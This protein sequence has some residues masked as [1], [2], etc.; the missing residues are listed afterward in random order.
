M[1]ENVKTLKDYLQ[2]ARRRKYLIAASALLLLVASIAVALIL[3][4]VYQS[5]ATILIE[6]QQIPT[7]LV[8]STV[9]SYADERI[10]LIQQRVMT[11]DNL[12][13]IIDKFNLY[14]EQKEKLTPAELAEQFRM[15]AHLELVNADVISQGRHSK[16]TLAFKLLFDDKDPLLAQKVTNELVTLFLNENVRNRTE[17]AEETTVFLE[18]EAQ[19][20]KI[21][22]Q[23][24]ENELAEYKEKY[25]DSLPELLPVNLSAVSRIE[26]E[27]QQLDLREKMLDERKI[28][29]RSQMAVAGQN[30]LASTSDGSAPRSLAELKL[31]QARLLSKYS[32]THPDVMRVKRQVEILESG[33]NPEQSEADSKLQEAKQELAKLRQQYSDNHPDVKVA[34]RKVAELTG[35][36]SPSAAKKPANQTISDPTLLQIKSEIDVAEVEL[37]NI[38]IHR[39]ELQEKLK[40]LEVNISQTHQVERG[41]YELMR[42]LDNN[43][44]KYNEL[45]A[46]QLEA[47]LAQTLE[48]EQKAEKF[49]LIEPPLLP[50]KPIKPNRL[51]LLFIGFIASI[52]G[53]FGAGLLREMMDD[54]IRGHRSLAHIVGA[55][56]LVVVPYIKSQ[57][58]IDRTRRNIIN[59][60]I[61]AG[62]LLLGMI[63]SVH[64][65]YMPLDI[66]WYKTWNRLGLI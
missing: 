57:E 5:Q 53:G 42:D 19:K 3:P 30:S 40:A 66:L 16:A 27:I 54:S 31:E 11:T 1:E 28:S 39:A 38:R 46:K 15:N 56:P 21:D 8:K 12:T 50:N 60:S 25:R 34:Q 47:K 9:T 52:G 43:K 20:F 65:L 7:D 14:H 35:A 37:A 32:A 33:Q 51:K 13:K 48:E 58:D 64:M 23:K 6:Q 4:P 49:S 24:I 62:V 26:S 45:K 59:F 17:R 18:A 63:V 29:L 22:I 44:A 10:S 55:E 36:Q 61:I 41:Y 2:I